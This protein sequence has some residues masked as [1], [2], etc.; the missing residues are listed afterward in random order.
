MTRPAAVIITILALVASA[1][2]QAQKA[3]GSKEGDHEFRDNKTGKAGR[4]RGVHASKIKPTLT[5]T[6]LKFTLV[7]KDK[8]P[9]K[10]IVISLTAPDGKK[11]YTEESD[12]KGYAE[13]LVPA[14]HTYELVYL[15][16]GRRKISAKV[17]VEDEPNQTIK[18]TL[19]YK[20]HED[21]ETRTRRLNGAPRFVLRGVE[22]DTGKATIRKDSFDRLDSVV[23]YMAHKLSSRVE[24]SGHTDN[25]GKPKANKLL[26]KKRAQTCRKYLISKGIDGKRIKAV[27]RGDEQ[28]IDTN[29]TEEGRQRN[30]RI[31]A[32]GY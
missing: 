11:Y 22:F 19:R 31:E 26:S 1:G 6:A 14:G 27:G 18:L 17:P 7:D 28:P 13:V 30:R 2:A 4:S 5:E 29:T 12:A 15:S 20:R 3:K 24:I 32:T 9:I 16:L 10:G 8:G 25:V 23:E 21:P